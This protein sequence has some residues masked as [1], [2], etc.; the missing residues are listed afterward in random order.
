LIIQKAVEF[1]ISS[2]MMK[3]ATAIN[4]FQKIIKRKT[5]S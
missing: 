3:D 5:A 2:G 1:Q 4:Q